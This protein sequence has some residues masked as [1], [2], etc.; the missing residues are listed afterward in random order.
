MPATGYTTDPRA[1][2]SVEGRTGAVDVV[3]A[4]VGLGS[5][6]NTADAA[7]PVSTAT[8]T[9]LDGKAN[10]SHSH[11]ASDTTSGTF[12]IGRI[13]VGTTSS[14]V[15]QGD[16]NHDAA[17]A[18]SGHNHSGT[19]ANASHT[20]AAADVASGTLDIG[21]V[22]TGTSGT[23]VAVGNHTHGVATGGTG[24]ASVTMGSYLVGNGT[25]AL[26]QRT[27]TETQTD[28]SISLFGAWTGVGLV[29]N[30]LVEIAAAWSADISGTYFDVGFRAAAGGKLEG[31]GRLNTTTNYTA[32]VTIF[33]LPAALCPAKNLVL[34]VRIGGAGAAAAF[35]TITSGGVGSLSASFTAGAGSWIQLDSIG[36]RR[37]VI[38]A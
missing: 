37:T 22:P 3:K 1:V 19:Y 29:V 38:G 36:A 23:T 34:D 20:H 10:T 28:L 7:K 5:V 14:T 32:G 4:D 33:T 2:T 25:G 16:H 12:A 8:Q 35:L 26:T 27:V 24:L 13:P 31:S 30:N 17:Y 11:A 15:A 21:R 6:D 9:A 18:T